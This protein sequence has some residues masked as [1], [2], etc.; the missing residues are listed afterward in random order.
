MQSALL[1][2]AIKT[3]YALPF[4]IFMTQSKVVARHILKTVSRELR[5]ILVC[6]RLAEGVS[7]DAASFLLTLFK[8]NFELTLHFCNSDSVG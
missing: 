4:R 2:A 5:H 6:I 3:V 7:F 1:P 8:R